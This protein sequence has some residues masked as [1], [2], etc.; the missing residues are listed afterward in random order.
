MRES[1]TELRVK[2]LD[3]L[4]RGVFGRVCPIS[5]APGYDLDQLG[6]PSLRSVA[7]TEKLI[8][9]SMVISGPTKVGKST[10]VGVALLGAL[11][12]AEVR[13]NDSVARE[14]YWA[15]DP[16]KREPVGSQS[17]EKLVTWFYA[18][19]LAQ[20]TKQHPLGAG[21]CPA[22]QRAKFT[23]LL[24]IDDLGLERDQ[25]ELVDVYHSRYEAGRV[26]WTTTGLTM[27]QLRE[28]YGEA[29]VRRMLECGGNPGRTVNCFPKQK[30][31]A[32]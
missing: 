25:A 12:R 28:R 14:V 26:T 6:H 20:A 21:E 16:K 32:A 11:C 10:A 19:D 3:Q 5:W 9:R 22:V 30:A 18:R 31:N 2:Y 23:G 8:E 24:V 1:T 27:A 4:R 17:S 15:A 29:F 13:T 7:T